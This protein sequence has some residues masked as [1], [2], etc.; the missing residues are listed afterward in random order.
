MKLVG[1][2]ETWLNETYSKVYKGKN[3]S[4]TF[5]LHNGLKQEDGLEALLFNF[6]LEY[7]I[8]K[9]K[10]TRWDWKWMEHISFW[11]MLMM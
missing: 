11:S 5:P 3:S 2:I 10:K 8:R 6:A 9:T 7:T 4:D 1:L